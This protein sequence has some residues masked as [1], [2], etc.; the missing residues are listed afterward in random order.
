MSDKANELVYEML[1]NYLFNGVGWNDFAPWLTADRV[2]E[3]ALDCVEEDADEYYDSD[4][5]ALVATPTIR[6][7]IDW[8]F[9]ADKLNEEETYPTNIWMLFGDD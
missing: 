8:R 6:E 5:F 2:E 7:T 1:K 4:W 3:I 9:I